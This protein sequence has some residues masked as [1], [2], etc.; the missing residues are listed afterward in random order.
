MAIISII[1]RKLIYLHQSY[2]PHRHI[3]TARLA[4]QVIAQNHQIQVHTF[5]Q[6]HQAVMYQQEDMLMPLFL[7]QESLTQITGQNQLVI[8][9]R[10]QN[11]MHLQPNQ[12][13]KILL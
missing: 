5:M 1:S 4:D 9:L 13:T 6:V 2:Q 8:M 10:H 3:G 11:T 7:F 12:S